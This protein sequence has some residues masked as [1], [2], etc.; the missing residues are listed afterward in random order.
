M[1]RNILIPGE[2]PK[3]AQCNKAERKN[4]TFLKSTI[5]K[6]LSREDFIQIGNVF[7]QISLVLMLI[8][9]VA[10]YLHFEIQ[11][12]IKAEDQAQIIEKILENQSKECRPHGHLRPC[13]RTDIL[14]ILNDQFK[15]SAHG[16]KNVS[17]RKTDFSP[18][19]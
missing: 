16:P 1:D 15:D 7:L 12:E 2:V 17:I 4:Q 14:G 5:R 10:V 18:I 8:F 13:G 19:K 9:V 11:N 6:K 3:H